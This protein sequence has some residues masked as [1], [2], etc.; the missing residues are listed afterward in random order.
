MPSSSPGLVSPATAFIGNLGYVVVAVVGGVQIATGHITLGN[1][2][3][4]VQ[5]LRQ[6][7]TPVNQ[8]A[9]M[10][11]AL[12][13]GMA[14]AERVFELLDEPEEAPGPCSA[15]VQWSEA[16]RARRV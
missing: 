13:S 1:I 8:V 16:A 14:S 9:G 4:F 3:A 12:Q 7:N 11:N 6:F 5:Y 2:Q 15:A 10:Y